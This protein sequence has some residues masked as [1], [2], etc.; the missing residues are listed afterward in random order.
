VAVVMAN[1]PAR[2]QGKA[3]PPSPLKASGFVA[4]GPVWAGPSRSV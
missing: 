2:L 4:R 3:P 1:S